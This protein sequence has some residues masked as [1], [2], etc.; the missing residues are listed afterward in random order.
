MVQAKL[1]QAWEFPPQWEN[2]TLPAASSTGLYHCQQR[3]PHTSSNS[4]HLPKDGPLVTVPSS[5]GG[6]LDFFCTFCVFPPSR[7]PAGTC[8]D[9]A[10]ALP[11]AASSQLFSAQ[12]A[13]PSR[14]TNSELSH[15]CQTEEP[16]TSLLMP[17]ASQRDGGL[18]TSR[19]GGKQ[20]RH[21]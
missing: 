20:S 11:Q 15:C 2:C 10:C 17:L 12:G 7:Q 21:E 1:H 4:E 18:V 8:P 13:F 16:A 9:T 19:I 3:P 14:S 5:A 6:G